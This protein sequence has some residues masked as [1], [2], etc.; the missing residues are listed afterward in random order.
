VFA[1]LAQQRDPG[2]EAH[3]LSGPE[4]L[5]RRIQLSRELGADGFVLFNLTERLRQQPILRSQQVRSHRIQMH[6]VTCRILH[7]HRARQ[8]CEH[9]KTRSG[10]KHRSIYCSP[11]LCPGRGR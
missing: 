9:A 3:K 6:V 8:D 5:A 2:T 1:H 4:Q 7:S 11:S 10:L